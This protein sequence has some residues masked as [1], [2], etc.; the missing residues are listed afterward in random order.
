[1]NINT[2]TSVTAREQISVTCTVGDIVAEFLES[3][4]VGTAF[5][6]VSIHNI[7]MLDAIARRGN[8]RFVPSRGEAGAVHMADAAAR[9]GGGLAIAFT[10]TGAGAGNAAGA[11]I[12]AWVGGTPVLHLTGQ[13]NSDCVDHGRAFIHETKDQLSMLRSVSKAAFRINRPEQA[14]GVLQAAARTALEAPAGPVS[15]E[16]PADIQAARTA[17]P[18]SFAPPP[19]RAIQAD[20]TSIQELA[21]LLCASR[22][23]LLWL[24]GGA[25]NAKAAARSL[26]DLG[27]GIVTS[28]NG[29]GIVA[30]DHPMTL[31]AFN[32][33]PP[34]EALYASSDLMIVAGSRMRANET[35]NWKLTL[36]GQVAQIDA[37]PSAQGRA[38]PCALF[39]NGD[40]ANVLSCVADLVEGKLSIDPA[41]PNDLQRA[42]LA[43]EAKMVEMIAPYDKI[44]DDLQATVSANSPWVRDVTIS[45]STWGNRLFKVFDTHIAVH[46]IGGGIGQGLSMAVGAATASPDEKVICLTGDGGLSVNIGE[47]FTMMQE[48]A[49]VLILLMND[50]GYGVIKNI[51]DVVCEGRNFYTE[52]FNPE[53]GLYAKSMR[54][55]HWKVT[56]IEQFRPSLEQAL[57]TSGPAMIEVDMNAIGPFATPFGGPPGI[58]GKS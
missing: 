19:A 26:A 32:M 16:I 41:L 56:G 42:R 45:N 57:A 3:C 52:L 7:P 4:G 47:M 46:S 50:G 53:F 12:E 14:L 38:Y 39:V 51:Q 10:S 15:V 48:N 58:A 30:E 29:R 5:G 18:K 54:L 43:S 22:R 31:G 13:I 55:P 40:C 2:D 21:D 28:G 24:G 36:P 44:V 23:P 49:N 6:V 35:K 17:R 20:P 11:L 34:V 27:V 25:R 8:I 37:D 9:V 33:T 1:M